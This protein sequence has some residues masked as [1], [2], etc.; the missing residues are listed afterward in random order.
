M[1]NLEDITGMIFGRL[2]AIQR[3]A[4]DKNHHSLW[5]CEC[6]CEE[7]NLIVVDIYSLKSGHTKSCGCLKKETSCQN[8]KKSRD[9][10]RQQSTI[11]GETKTRLY[12]IWSNMKQRCNNISHKD[13]PNYGGRG[14]TYCP[15]WENYLNFRIWAF[16]N[17]YNNSLTLDRID[18]NGN[19]SPDNCKWATLID[20]ARNKRKTLYMT[21]GGVTHTLCEWAEISGINYR[22]LKYRF[23]NGWDESEIFMPVNLN[24]KNIRKQKESVL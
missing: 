5:Q 21:I 16:D 22:T 15:E 7:H 4:F 17:G 20:Q 1:I 9:K 10:I 14:I 6:S 18:C 2:K 23:Q 13:Y 12:H 11:H 3:I 8:G 19:Y 24:N